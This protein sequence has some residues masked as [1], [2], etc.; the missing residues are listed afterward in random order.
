MREVTAG[1]WHWKAP[2][3]EWNDRQ[4]WER[5]VSSYA[6]DT[7]DAVLLFDPLDVPP[8]LLERADAVVLTCPWHRRDAPRLGLPIFVPPPDPP[9]PDPVRGEVF[10]AGDTL[11]FGVRAFEGFEPNDL[12]LYVASRRAVVVGDTLIDRGDGLRI[13][14]DW[15]VDA[16]TPGDVARRLRP[17][18]DLPVDVVLPTHAEPADRAALERALAA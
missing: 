18:L 13:H 4:E 17:L 2:H 15:P 7:G 16:V 1:V 6:I 12:V 5:L 9:D 14:P 3:P 11:R 10:R 8:A